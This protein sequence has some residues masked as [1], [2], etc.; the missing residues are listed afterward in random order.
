MMTTSRNH[1][2]TKAGMGLIGHL[3]FHDYGVHHGSAAPTAG[4]NWGI[5]AA[6]CLASK[7]NDPGQ[8]LV[9]V[10][11]AAVLFAAWPPICAIIKE[12]TSFHSVLPPPPKKSTATGGAIGCTAALLTGIMANK[13]C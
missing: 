11:V 9:L 6:V 13:T 1:D 2:V 3:A 7:L 8:A 5:F 4:L 12:C 10:L